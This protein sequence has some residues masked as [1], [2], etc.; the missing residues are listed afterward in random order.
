MYKIGADYEKAEQAAHGIWLD[1]GIKV[2][3]MDLVR[4]K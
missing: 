4:Q 3:P 1:Y 2:V